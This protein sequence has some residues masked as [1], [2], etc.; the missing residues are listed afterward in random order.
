MTWGQSPGAEGLKPDS[1]HRGFRGIAIAVLLCVALPAAAQPDLIV[2][3]ISGSCNTN[4][5]IAISVTVRN[6]GTTSAAA[7]LIGIYV[8]TDS[9]ITTADTRIASV[10][11]TLAAGSNTTVTGSVSQPSVTPGT[12]TVGALADY[13]GAVAESNETNNS[14]AGNALDLPCVYGDPDINIL[15]TS[16]TFDQSLKI[17]E[18]DTD[19]DDY[20]DDPNAIKLKNNPFVADTST[21]SA[22]TIPSGYSIVLFDEP[23]SLIHRDQLEAQGIEVLHW[24]PNNALMVYSPPTKGAI[25]TDGVV[26]TGKLSPGDKISPN[27]Q[28]SLPKG[29][30]LVEV[31]PNVTAAAAQAAIAEA[32]GKV[33]PNPY[34][35]PGTYLVQADANIVFLLSHQDEVSW[36]HAALDPVIYGQPFFQCPGPMTPFGPTAKFVIAGVGWDGAGR[37]SAAITYKFVNGTLDIAGSAEEPEVVEAMQEWAKY[38]ELSFST[39][40]LVNQNMSIDIKWATGDHGDGS[41]FD[42]LSGVL[43]HAFYPFPLSSE[44][45]AGDLHFDDA[46]TWSTSNVGGWDTYSI[47]LHELGHAL[48]LN[49]SEVTTAIMYAFIVPGQ[50]HTGLKPDDIAGIQTM[51]ASAA[52]DNAF[53]IANNGTNYLTVSAITPETTAAWLT[54]SPATPFEVAP[55]AFTPVTVNVNYS[56]APTGTSIRRLLVQSNDPDENPYPG[57]VDVFVTATGAAAPTVSVGA[58][59]TTLT[60]GGPVT[61]NVTYTDATTVSLSAANVTLIRT[62]T[63]NGTVAVSGTG[64]TT[65]TITVSS[66]TGDG[67][68]AVSLAAGT[69]SNASG[70]AGSAGPSSTCTVDNTRPTLSISDPSATVVAGGPI[71]YTLTYA[72]ASAVSLVNGNVSL[73]ATGTAAGTATVSGSGTTTRTITIQGITGNGTLKIQVAAGTASDAAGNTALAV[74]AATAFT[75][76]N[77]APGVAIGAPSATTTNVG[78]VAYTVTYSDVFSVSLT[79]AMVTVNKTGTA[80]AASVA[81][82]GTGTSR[83]VTLSGVTGN[84]TLGISIAAGSAADVAGN[85]APAAG[86]SATFTVDNILPT[87]ALGAPSVSATQSGP[88]T[89]AVTYT[90]ANTVTLSSANVTL[91]KTGTANGTVSVTGSGTASRTVTVSGI[92]GE[93]DMSVSIA[94]GTASDTA[95]NVAPAAGPSATFTADNTPPTPVIGA[96]SVTATR[97][98]PVTYTLTYSGAASISLVAGNISLNRTGSANADVAI[99]GSGLATRTVTLSNITGDGTIGIS[100][101]AGTAV[102]GAGL[103][104]GAAGPSATFSADNTAPVPVIGGPSAGAASSGPIT[105]TVDYGAGAIVTLATSDITLNKTG[106]ANASSVLVTGSGTTRTITI[107]AISGDGAIG[108]SIAPGTASDSAGN[109]ALG[110]GPSATF[111]ADNTAPGVTIGAPS[112][113][114]TQSGPVSYTVTYTGASGVTLANSDVSLIVNGTANATVNVSGSGTASRTVTLSSITGQGSLSIAIAAGTAVDAAGN[115]AGE[116]GP[117]TA[118]T[119][120]S[121]GPEITIGAPDVSETGAGPVNFPISYVDASSV[122]LSSAHVTLI[123]TGTA[124]GSVSVTGSGLT[125][126]TVT[127]SSITGNGTLGISIAAGTATDAASNAAPAAGPSATVSVDNAPPTVVIGSPTPSVS[128]A[129]S[130]TFAVTYSGASSVT[131][132]A[133]DVTLNTSGDATGTVLVTGSGTTS[134]TVTVSGVS[135]NGTIGISLGAGTAT[136]AVGNAATTAGP[137][138]TAMIDTTKPTLSIGAPSVSETRA[139]P[140]SF[141]V[142]Y[143]GASAIT[144]A[145]A[146]VTLNATGTATG[147][148]AVTGSG[149]TTRTVTVSSISGDG[150]LSISLGSGTAVDAAANVSDAQGPSG[151]VSVDNTAPLVELSG[152]SAAITRNGP[153]TFTATYS[154]ASEVTL[155]PAQ[156]TLTTTG[157]A[158][159]TVGVSGSGVTTRTITL[160]SITGTGTIAVS[161]QAGT[162]TDAIGNAAAGVGPSTTL[163]VDNTAPGISISAPSATVTATGPVTYTVTYTDASSV[164]LASGDITLAKTGTAD[165]NVSVSGSGTS[166]RTVT[167]DSVS[168]NGTIGISIASATASDLA[169]NTA[170]A[171]GPSTTFSANPGVISV[172]IEEP[173]VSL[174]RGGPVQ[175]IVMYNNADAIT[176]AAG[177]IAVNKTGTVAHDTPVV[178]GSGT[179]SRTVTLNNLTG[180]GTVS[181]SLAAGTAT[182]SGSDPAPAAGPSAAFVVDNTA[183]EGVITLLN[184]SPTNA[185]AVAFALTFDE[186]LTTEILAANIVPTGTLAAGASVVVSGAN[187][188][189]TVTVTP[190]NPNASGTLGISVSSAATD[191]AGNPLTIEPGAPSYTIDNSAPTISV[192]GPTPLATAAGP[193]SFVITY[194]GAD[195]ITLSSANITLTGAGAS[196]AS[197]VVGGTGATRT[198]TLSSISGTGTLGFNVA[199]GTASDAAGNSAASASTGTSLTVDNTRP[200]ISVGAPSV[201]ATRNGP[202]THTVTYGGATSVSLTPAFITLV[203]SGDANGAVAV[204]GS[205]TTTRTV[206]ISSITGSGTIGLQIAADSASDAV[207]NTANAVASTTAFVVDN[208]APTMSIGAPSAT[209][210]STAAVSFPIAYV[211]ATSISLAS[212]NVSLT[213]TGTATAS[214]ITVTGSGTTSRTVTLSNFSGNGTIAISLA[215]NTAQDLAGNQTAAAGPSA[216]V[217]VDSTAPTIA[218]GSPSPLETKSGPV[219]YTVTYVGAS[220]ITLNASDINVTTSGTATASVSVT[221][222]GTSTR[223]VTFHTISGNGTLRFS[224]AAGSATDAAGNAAA[225]T[226]LSSSVFV[227]NTAPTLT[228]GAPSTTLTRTGP[229][230]YTVTYTGATTVTLAPSHVTLYPTG[231]AAATIGVSGTGNTTRTVTLS[232]ITGD[233]S[234]AISIAAASASDVAGNVAEGTGISTAFN[235]DNTGPTVSV[236]APS[237]SST[238]VG[239]VTF[240]VTYSGATSVTL[241]TGNVTLSKTGTANAAVSVTGSGTTSRTVTL[242]GVTGEGTLGITIQSGTAVDGAA[243]SAT[244]SGASATVLVDNTPPTPVI[245]APTPTVTTTGPINFNVTYPGASNVTLSSG[246]ITLNKTGTANAGSIVVSGAGTSARLVSLSSIT[247]DGTL[248]ISIAAGTAVDEIGNVA[249]AA[250]PSATS[251]VDTT[252]PTVSVGVPSATVTRVGPVTYTVTY[253]GAAQVTLA[254]NDITLSK[255]G[256]AN[257]VVAVT[258]S[259]TTTRTVTISSITGN[260]ALGIAVGPGTASDAA[261]NLSASVPVGTTFTADNTAPTIA[262]SG[263]SASITNT[264]PV[265]YTATY[266]GASA[267]TLSAANV[268]LTRTGTADGIV[269]VTGSGTA[270]RTIS[271]ASITGNGALGISIAAGTAA[272]AVGNSAAGAASTTSVNVDNVAPTLTL[273]APSTTLTRSGPITYTLTYGGATVISLASANL[274]LLTTGNATGVLS[275]SGGGLTTRTATISGITGDGTVQLAVAAGTAADSA[276]NPAPS[277]SSPTLV[278]VDNTAPG[279]TISAPSSSV[280]LSG[281]VTY[282]ISYTGATDVTL[283]PGHITVNGTASVGNVAVS[284]TGNV[285]RT[286]TLSGISGTGSLGI[287]VAAGTASDDAGNAAPAAGPSATF[288]VDPNALAVNIGTPSSGLTRTGPVSFQVTY[289]GATSVTLATGNITLNKTG[290]A[291]GVVAVTGSGTS[292]RTVT[293]SGITGNGALSI[294]VAAGTATGAAGSAPAAGPSAL[295]VVDNTAPDAVIGGP[296][297]AVTKDTQ[298]EY[299]VTYPDAA[300]IALDASKILVE[301]TGTAAGLVR[302]DENGAMRNVTFQFLQGDG[303]LAFRIGA[304]SAVDAAG[305]TAGEISGVVPFTVDHTPP[306]VSLSEPSVP[307]TT[308]GPVTYTVT[309]NGAAEISLNPFDIALNASGTAAGTVSVS[310]SGNA[311]RTVTISNISGDGSMGISI[312]A[313]SAR[314][315]VEND[316]PGAFLS[317]QFAVNNSGPE[318]DIA[319][320]TTGSLQISFPSTPGLE[321]DV[322]SKSAFV[323]SYQVIDTVLA[324]APTVE[325]VAPPPAAPEQYFAIRNNGTMSHSEVASIEL[326]LHEGLNLVALPVVPSSTGLNAILGD[327]LTGGTNEG[328][329]DRVWVWD[330]VQRRYSYAWLAEGLTGASAAFN[331]KWFTGSAETTLTW[332]PD[333]GVWIEIRPGHGAQDVR[334]AGKLTKVDRVIP[335]V[336]GLNLVG[337]S[338]PVARPLGDQGVG[339]A[340]ANLYESGLTGASNEAEADRFWSWNGTGYDFEWL[341]DGVNTFYNGQWF[342]GNSPSTKLIEPGVGYWVEILPEHGPVTWFYPVPES[343]L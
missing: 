277:V 328:S 310:G 165:A 28:E 58:P 19:S 245:G 329:A 99:S 218:L 180:D 220:A 246:N 275:V 292:S 223:T 283:N 316:A 254:S 288:T 84:G 297:L 76:D 219:N 153:I 238:T 210:T 159:A 338:C 9:T 157:T 135:G 11:R 311:T 196:A 187:P 60:T 325:Y 312:A 174:T 294:S 71:T 78:P 271:I 241:A 252:P 45:I 140:V 181:I 37:S 36:I 125:A 214:T 31:F 334:I 266:S 179:V 235:V 101:A 12:F 309:Y 320:E 6:Q 25:S 268:S 243:N 171:A 315:A 127:I 193:A 52:A 231:T 232:G 43:A 35:L 270:T 106:T 77:T 337:P 239:P 341:V 104:A 290:T 22:V 92:T 281:P 138:T 230:T 123:K 143:T 96:P 280:T 119:I 236:G 75:V 207:G 335:L 107:N 94:A 124:D 20:F 91:I 56:L 134:R 177:N 85:T 208:S 307:A 194:T 93:G 14:L 61:F 253:G 192:G 317:T 24:V 80:N 228:V 260:G 145:P 201:A 227:D 256:T 136:D 287:S 155:A 150:A 87:I 322:L 55:G 81:V 261:G 131:L 8:S 133:T 269:S 16:L 221:G 336:V 274:S 195:T 38:A 146:D 205:G 120:D 291:N 306:T 339:E 305:N 255:T 173:S 202:V 65:R 170:P 122:T 286:V 282:S 142:T 47:A 29:F 199:A 90:G 224:I 303:T 70:S 314:D 217:T 299:T 152:P 172:N 89:Y 32:G 113:A 216:A 2:N 27:I 340:D 147:S 189:Y 30:V 209:L 285:G 318:V 4:G 169:G 1:G 130:V 265:T 23:L 7:F 162:A 21:K 13:A 44:T 66:I 313:G 212:G 257:G 73:V 41:S 46:E 182:A 244:G 141:V 39:T 186:L 26:W 278:T 213:T 226:A 333:R 17:A 302:V 249:G 63:A 69:A 279:I 3:S 40:T 82:T 211:D 248:G 330:P 132:S 10:S 259:G 343:D 331:G 178:S 54:T 95:G 128:G 198:V 151:A 295:V 74:T 98:G 15:K 250:G 324:T 49:H 42:G 289:S 264:G 86:P 267:V 206:T 234:L 103:S 72:G 118:V 203:K 167:L 168:G 298:V 237:V 304:G 327:Q 190:S 197:V 273:G 301:S 117:S 215:A 88:V 57:A 185:N 144:L 262:V 158:A 242:S 48:G 191:A 183:P 251:S 247:G 97:N 296:S 18:K 149:T 323:S 284:G 110:A 62:G 139:G 129:G 102:D 68:I 222:S 164:T 175:F 319:R 59:S 272:D 111:V 79:Q 184:S 5:S 263:P 300:V 276:N 34:L 163:I 225:A 326:N 229:V 188:A 137:S 33:V 116:A 258:G 64:T 293:L 204:S 161:L 100:V 148:V 160:S 121:A 114:V 154:G 51:Y 83:T 233:G 126:R 109:S 321:Y 240:P 50:M 166:T 308:T 156:V 112:P 115:G 200:T 53:N 332:Q 108:I 67:T 105:Y 342:H 176:L